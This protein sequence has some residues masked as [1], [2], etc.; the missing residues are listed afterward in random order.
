MQWNLDQLRQFI[1]AAEHGS[2]SAAAR[3][4]GKAQSA[5]STA[6]GLLE[7]DL[8]VELFD[9]TRHRVTLSDVGQLL[10]L[11][12]Q[13]LLRQAQSLD[14]LALLLSDGGKAKLALAFDEALPYTAIGHLVHEISECFP[15]MELALFNGTANE[16]ASYVDQ[17]RADIAFHFDRGPLR[18]CFDQ[19]YIGSLPQG[20]FVASGHS[21]LDEQPVARKDLARYRQLLIHAE[22]EQAIAYSPRLWRSD[23]FYCIAEMIA[24]N[25]GWAI[26]PVN[27]A[28]HE[29][30]LKSLRQVFCPSLVLPP[31]PVRM[32]WCHGGQLD[33]NTEWISTRFAELLKLST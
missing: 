28:K 8:G 26:L 19:R 11:E 4:L 1:A 32:I 2:I 7:A 12:A 13:E 10:L 29:S 16:V 9:R 30:Y 22:D 27:I 17:K 21:L 33:P 14:Q 24:D 23:S 25:L 5:V 31:L 18:N 3:H 15:Y 20:I 6:I